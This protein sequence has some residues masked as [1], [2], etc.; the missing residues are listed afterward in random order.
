MNR[1]PFPFA[2]IALL[3]SLVVVALVAVAL[4]R[5]IVCSGRRAFGTLGA[6]GAIAFMSTFA[7]PPTPLALL[8]SV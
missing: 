5:L 2:L 7:L 6:A 4:Y 3:V 8:R 1:R